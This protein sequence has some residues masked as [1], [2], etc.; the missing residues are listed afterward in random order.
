MKKKEKYYKL[1]SPIHGKV[2]AESCI[3]RYSSNTVKFTKLKH[4][5]SKSRDNFHSKHI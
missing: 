5:L 2:Y 3:H 1:N 4:F